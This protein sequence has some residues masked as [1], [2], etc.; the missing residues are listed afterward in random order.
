MKIS[1]LALFAWPAHFSLSKDQ[2]DSLC[3]GEDV[4]QAISPLFPIK[5][6]RCVDCFVAKN[7]KIKNVAIYHR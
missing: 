6:D 2:G 5:T 3:F 7:T 4:G 1:A